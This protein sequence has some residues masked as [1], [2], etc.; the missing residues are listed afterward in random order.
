MEQKTIDREKLTAYLLGKLSA[1]E[2]DAVA[3]QYFIDDEL[4]DQ[5]LEVK[6]DLIDQ[7][8]R[9]QLP[10]AD[11]RQ[12]E[13]YLDKL[14]GGWR[15]VA[16][17][18]ALVKV[19]D[20]ESPAGKPATAQTAA[21]SLAPEPAGWRQTFAGWLAQPVPALVMATGLIVLGGAL[22]WLIL[23]YQ[24][25][26]HDR[27]QMLAQMQQR[28]AQQTQ[29]LRETERKLAEEQTSNA[30]L[31]QELESERQ[32]RETTPSVQSP[33]VSRPMISW[34]LSATV[35]RDPSQPSETVRLDP[36]AK[37]VKLTIP[38]RGKQTYTGYEVELKTEDGK[39]ILWKDNQPNTPPMRSGQNIVF[40]RP[41]SEFADP[42]SY[43]LTLTLISKEETKT[44]D[45]YFTVARR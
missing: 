31:R 38:M 8:A 14:P 16:V 32:L 34:L 15:E 24:Q 30:Q 29:S 33:A 39:Q 23:R 20:R 7:Y 12:F 6:A 40:Y 3:E 1:E 42:N 44:R 17:A 4:Y 41:A 26:S 25:L 43:K 21:A 28:D 11:R 5:L 2:Q 10:A 36:K 35:V 9:G 22:I 13:S 27:E 45:Y 18:R 37:T 19:I